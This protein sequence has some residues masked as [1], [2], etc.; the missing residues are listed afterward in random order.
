MY[1]A[2]RFCDWVSRSYR[3]GSS[4]ITSELTSSGASL[5]SAFAIVLAFLRLTLRIPQQVV[6]GVGLRPLVRIGAVDALGEIAAD[7]EIDG[8]VDHPR[9]AAGEGLR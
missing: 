5:T 3:R 7:A 1:S 4:S 8:H 2:V 9:A 6:A